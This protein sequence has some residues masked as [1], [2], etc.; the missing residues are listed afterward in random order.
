MSTIPPIRSL[1]GQRITAN[2]QVLLGVRRARRFGQTTAAE[3]QIYT[4]PVAGTGMSSTP[5]TPRRAVRRRSLS[6]IPRRR[7]RRARVGC[8]TCNGTTQAQVGARRVDTLPTAIE[9]FS[10]NMQAFYLKVQ[11]NRATPANMLLLLTQLNNMT[12]FLIQAFEQKM[13]ATTGIAGLWDIVEKRLT[14]GE[15]KP[16]S[17]E[18]I[19]V[20]A[21]DKM[22]GFS[23]G[24]IR[25]FVTNRFV[26]TA[27]RLNSWNRRLQ[28]Y[29]VAVGQCI[30][31]GSELDRNCIANKVT[32]PLLLG[33]RNVLNDFDPQPR[34]CDEPH[35][36]KCQQ[37][38][39][40]AAEPLLLGKFGLDTDTMR[41]EELDLMIA[42]MADLERA[43]AEAAAEGD[44]EAEVIWN[45]AGT[46]SE[47]AQKL[48]NSK[49][50]RAPSGSGPGLLGLG[51]AA[52]AIFAL[53]TLM[54]GKSPVK[55]NPRMKG[56]IKALRSAYS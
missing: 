40:D 8:G 34:E 33:Q 12:G 16:T 4:G 23:E 18:I 25:E 31:T 29:L 43:N 55:R 7:A 42:Q 35:S 2:G 26:A 11:P 30:G 56:R 24:A 47:A 37:V 17:A 50:A 52:A 53:G 41:R 19:E 44:D 5:S 49:P 46:T 9:N 6:V 15:K 10:A 21:S 20:I 32:V 14:F 36:K 3:P 27:K 28:S 45:I 51:V 1:T 13:K 54:G 48:W 22:T 38:V 39:A